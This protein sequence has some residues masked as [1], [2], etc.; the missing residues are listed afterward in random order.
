MKY[1]TIY[2]NMKKNHDIK[3]SRVTLAMLDEIADSIV[4][5]Q[6]DSHYT[7]AHIYDNHVYMALQSIA[8]M[9]GFD[10]ARF[11]LAELPHEE[12]GVHY[13]Y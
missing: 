10:N 9:Q 13:G 8:H 1:L 5:E 4:R 11:V 6:A 2:Y 3:E 7:K 12:P